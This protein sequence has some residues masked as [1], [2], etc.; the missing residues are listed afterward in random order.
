[1]S[2]RP[3]PITLA[4]KATEM[5]Q[6]GLLAW[7][8]PGAGHFFL[9]YRAFGLVYFLAI[10]F[11]YLAGV[12]IGGVKYSVNP[13]ENPWLFLAEIGVGSYT[14][15]FTLLSY[16]LPAKVEY[17]SYYPETDVAQIY[18]AVAGLLNVLA[19]LDALARSQTGGLP[20]Y[21][22]ELRHHKPPGTGESPRNAANPPRDVAGQAPPSASG[23]TK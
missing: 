22:H 3:R 21:Y 13:Q 10:S 15:L 8:L 14:V 23:A 19:V 5:L 16:S 4:D 6:A 2:S 17:L 1:M 20:V 9:G 11:P 7:I 12:L 18:L